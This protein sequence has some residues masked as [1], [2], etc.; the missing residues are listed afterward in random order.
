MRLT[1]LK[2]ANCDVIMSIEKLQHQLQRAISRFESASDV[3]SLFS[4]EPVRLQSRLHSIEK[5]YQKAT[6]LQPA[7]TKTISAITQMESNPLSLSGREWGYIAWGLNVD[8]NNNG[9][10]INQIDL[11]NEALSQ[12][13]K[14][15]QTDIRRNTWFG[16]LFSYFSLDITDME[17]SPIC[18][19]KLRELLKKSFNSLYDKTKNPRDWM[20]IIHQH[21]DILT[22]DIVEK[23]ASSVLVGDMTYTDNIRKHLNIT[24]NSWVWLE[25]FKEQINQACEAED[26]MFYG[27]ID[28]IL[29]ASRPYQNHL[30]DVIKSLLNRYQQSAKSNVVSASLKTVSF[31]KWGSPQLQTTTSWG[32]VRTETKAMVLQWFAKDDLEH[33]FSMLQDNGTPDL[34]RLNFW[35]R[36]IS[37][38]SY[39]RIVLGRGSLFNRTIDFV[40]F[41]RIN[42]GRYSMLSGAKETNNAFILKIGQY[43]IVEFSE[44]GNACYIYSENNMPFPY[45]KASLDLK[46]VKNKDFSIKR[47][48]HSGDWELSMDLTMNQLGIFSDSYFRKDDTIKLNTKDDSLESIDKAARWMKER[49]VSHKILYQSQAVSEIKKLFG[50]D[51]VYRQD[52]WNSGLSIDKRILTR[53]KKINE[54]LIRWDSDSKAW[55]LI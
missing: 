42:N 44:T 3:K 31:E 27:Y 41:R 23:M 6:E 33:F 36:Y 12:F 29:S 16:L 53:F 30:N 10:L 19:L 45:S 15:F 8:Y 34:R 11:C 21:P 47:I 14:I 20:R 26:S 43:Y 7:S 49:V 35:L 24:S 32:L 55:R 46:D 48:S 25:L 5:L 38:I 18:W 13:E 40:N 1:S 22:C 52:G 4:V 28:P 54:D 9:K 2:C 51:F 50:D 37:Q 17:R 39:T